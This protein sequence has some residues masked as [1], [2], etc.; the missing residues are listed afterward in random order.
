MISKK[1]DLRKKLFLLNERHSLLEEITKTLPDMIWSKNIKGEYI[2]ANEVICNN[3]LSCN[4]DEV[5]GKTDVYFAQREREKYSN[6]PEWH[7]FGE[8]C[9]DSDFIVQLEQKPMR[10]RE[11]GNIKGKMVYLD[12]Y[13]APLIDK[14]TGEVVGTVGNGRDITKEVLLEKELEKIAYYDLLTGLKNRTMLEVT[15]QTFIKENFKKNIGVFF[16]LDLDDFKNINDTL[17]HDAGD[18]F[19]V[20]IANKIKFC[21]LERCE[22]FRFGGDEFVIIFDSTFSDEKSALKEARR[23]AEQLRASV[24]ASECLLDSSH[25]DISTTVSIGVTLI[26]QEENIGISELLTRA[27]IS[28]YESKRNG[29]NGVTVFDESLRKKIIKA[30]KIKKDIKKG[31][32]KKEFELYYQPQINENGVVVGAEALIRWNKNN[33]IIPP[34]YFID[35]AEESGQIV[36]IG[37]FV[38]EEGFKKVLEWSKDEK[39]KDIV[40]SLNVSA[41]QFY[42][43]GFLHFVYYLLER[44]R[45]DVSKIKF[46]LTESASID[47]FEK[48]LRKMQILRSIG[49]NISLDD[50]GTGYSSLSYLKNLP[51]SQVKIDK[52]FIDNVSNNECDK[53]MVKSILDISASLGLEVVAEGVETAEQFGIL[54]EMGCKI[55]QGYYFAKPMCGDV[56]KQNFSASVLTL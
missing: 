28:M 8:L 22:M 36:D 7:T 25:S 47:S 52:S 53:A 3:L 10:F 6:N 33:K 48:S 46:E 42:S 56:F 12:V 35:V 38:L 49:I 41:K 15:L 21:C 4:I 40:L 39:L 32:Y 51:L 45:I 26:K 19:L 44:C 31:L 9:S 1:D 29:K 17:G 37:N 43:E 30:E 24:E 27:D 55:F 20:N 16:F 23:R 14:K 54:K 34:S 2:Y 13:K 18:E 5:K 11:S 50:F